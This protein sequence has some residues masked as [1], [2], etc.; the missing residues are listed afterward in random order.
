M[1]A[2]EAARHLKR[3]VSTARKMGGLHGITFAK[4]KRGPKPGTRFGVR[5]LLSSI[6]A[7][8]YDVCR[9]KRLRPS[10]ALVAIG[11]AD[12]IEALT[13]GHGA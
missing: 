13:G 6:E 10:E 8:D 12:L 4:G 5:R 3:S 1:T 11:R 7:E 9:E 2:P